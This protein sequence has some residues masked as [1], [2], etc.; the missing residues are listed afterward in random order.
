MAYLQKSMYKEGMAEFEKE[1]AISPG[2]PVALSELG[3]AYAVAGR[4]AEAQKVLDQLN[5]LS[6]Q[7]Y[8]PAVAH[9]RESMWAL[10]RRTR[11]SSGWK[12]LMRTALQVSCKH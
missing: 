10:G 8:V 12:R 3:Y 6:K 5:E 9:G 7:K 4:R 11:H 2:N 1:L